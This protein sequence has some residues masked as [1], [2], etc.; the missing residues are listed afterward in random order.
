MASTNRKPRLTI[1][2]QRILYQGIA[3]TIM[4]ALIALF[5]VGLPVAAGTLIM[6]L[7]GS[8]IVVGI[9]A[10]VL[11]FAFNGTAAYFGSV[12]FP[13]IPFSAWIA[14]AL[15][16]P[17]AWHYFMRENDSEFEK[18][19]SIE[20]TYDFSEADTPLAD[21]KSHYAC[22]KPEHPSND[23]MPKKTGAH[24]SPNE[25]SLGE[26]VAATLAFS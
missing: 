6:T 12:H 14:T 11:G 13:V 24:D 3:I 5:V 4:A 26:E 2:Q 7:G 15:F 18:K 20:V 19:P 23:T 22:V 10:M 25:E 21:P 8:P 9:A 16:V 17:G 1:Q